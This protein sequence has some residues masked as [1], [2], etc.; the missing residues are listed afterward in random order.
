MLSEATAAT[1]TYPGPLGT[2]ILRVLAVAG[3]AGLTS[4]VMGPLAGPGLTRQDAQNRVN[5]C[6]NRHLH[7]AGLVTRTGENHTRAGGYRWHITPAG[8][9]VAALPT[10]AEAAEA[11]W[12][13]RAARQDEAGAALARFAGAGYGPS[14]SPADKRAAAGQLREAGCSLRQIGDLFGVT[15]EA[16]RKWLPPD[17]EGT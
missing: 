8:R 16:V 14:S 12:R 2:A 5:S 7:P 3:P 10:S 13:A 11:S 6:L 9:E 1:V 4:T 15:H 17:S